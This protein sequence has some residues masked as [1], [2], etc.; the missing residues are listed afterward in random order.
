[1]SG[2]K[3]PVLPMGGA[4]SNPSVGG[5]KN[6]RKVSLVLPRIMRGQA[7]GKTAGVGGEREEREGG[8]SRT[9]VLVATICQGQKRT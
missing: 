4:S 7:W 6:L 9:L 5:R 1:V 3:E 8:R 2:P